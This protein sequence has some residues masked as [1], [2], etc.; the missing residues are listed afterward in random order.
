M[1]EATQKR[2]SFTFRIAHEDE[3]PH[4]LDFH[5]RYLTEHLWPRTLEEFERVAKDNCLYVAFET[6]ENAEVLVGIC[7]VMHAEDPKRLN[8]ERLEFGGVYVIDGC[9]G[10]GVATALGILAI[11]IHHVWD[12]PGGPLVAHVHEANQ[13]PRGMLQEHLGFVLVDRE[14]PPSGIAPPSMAR[15]QDGNV[16]GDLFRFDPAELLRFADLIEKFSG[17][18]S[19]KSGESDLYVD[20]PSVV[21]HRDEAVQALRDLALKRTRS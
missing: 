4:V 15:N 18:I 5:K 21:S 17:T 12:P 3:V 14:I 11:S 9:R 1:G 7:Y 20:L 8:T 13:L 6:M 10:Y 19:G 16:V 2:R